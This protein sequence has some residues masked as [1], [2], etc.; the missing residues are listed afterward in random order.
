MVTNVKEP[1]LS[2][3]RRVLGARGRLA[4]I[5]DSRACGPLA[6]ETPA[7]P[8]CPRL[9]GTPFTGRAVPNRS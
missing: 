5:V 4:R 3:E 9:P 7:L 2:W 8:G 1:C 6:V